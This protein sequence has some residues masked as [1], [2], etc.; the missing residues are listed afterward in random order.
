M[1][2]RAY[3]A[4]APLVHVRGQPGSIRAI[5]RRMFRQDPMLL[6]QLLH[7]SITEAV[8]LSP[9][10]MAI[11][12][13]NA[14]ELRFYQLNPTLLSTLHHYAI[15]HNLYKDLKSVVIEN[16]NVL[17]KAFYSIAKALNPTGTISEVVQLSQCQ[18]QRVDA[19]QI[20]ANKTESTDSD[21]DTGG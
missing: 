10:N 2:G 20:V 21:D 5:P 13:V 14:N 18:H 17:S 19:A 8:Q 6:A 7:H 1:A 11:F 12:I 16:P 15:S 4:N 9:N 3:E